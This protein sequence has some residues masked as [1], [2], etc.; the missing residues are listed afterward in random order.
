MIRKLEVGNITDVVVLP[1]FFVLKGEISILLDIVAPLVLLE[2][3]FLHLLE[4]SDKMKGTNV[5]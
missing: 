3:M 5:R 2:Y 1:A 4:A